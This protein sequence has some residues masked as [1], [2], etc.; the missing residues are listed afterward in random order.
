ME[1]LEL[2]ETKEKSFISSGFDV[3][4]NDLNS[5]LFDFQKYVVKIALKKGMFALFEDCGLGKTIQQLSWAEAVYNQGYSLVSY[6]RDTYGI[7]KVVEM[8]NKCGFYSF[9]DTNVIRY[10]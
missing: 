6:V 8:N 4:E 5:N 3:D 7:E 1:Y 10:E 2:L 9:S